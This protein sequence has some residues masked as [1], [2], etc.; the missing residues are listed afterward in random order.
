MGVKQSQT[1]KFDSELIEDLKYEADITNRPFNNYVEN[2]L[3]T[4]NGR[5][6]FKVKG[7]PKSKSKS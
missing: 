7:Y 1:F 4:H 3:K 6:I 2:L 5:P